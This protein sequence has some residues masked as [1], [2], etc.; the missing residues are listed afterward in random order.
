MAHGMHLNSLLIPLRIFKSVEGV[1]EAFQLVTN[2]HS[3][4]C[5]GSGLGP[6][7]GPG[8][9][10]AEWEVGAGDG[11]NT[12]GEHLGEGGDAG[13]DQEAREAERGEHGDTVT[14]L[15]EHIIVK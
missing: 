8:W 11:V 7:E 6:G 2:T 13:Q 4:V 12:G 9:G 3:S 14:R 15:G 5:G 1:S 10:S